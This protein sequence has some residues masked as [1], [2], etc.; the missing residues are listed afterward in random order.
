MECGGCRSYGSGI[1]GA[2]VG[3]VTVVTRVRSASMMVGIGAARIVGVVGIVM[4][5][6]RRSHRRD[7]VLLHRRHD[8][9]VDAIIGNELHGTHGTE[10]Q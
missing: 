4:A 9:I 2:I 5:A 8:G 3:V 6:S 7:T 1:D 10:F